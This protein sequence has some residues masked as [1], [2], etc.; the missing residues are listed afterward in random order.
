MSQPTSIPQSAPF[1][2]ILHQ[3]LRW[4][5]RIRW[6]AGLG[7]LATILLADRVTGVS[8]RKPP[9]YLISLFIFAYN[10]GLDHWLSRLGHSPVRSRLLTHANLQIGL[11]FLALILLVAFAGGVQNLFVFYV[12]FHI[13][14][15]S[16]LL[17]RGNMMLVTFFICLACTALF[18]IDYAGLIPS[19]FRLSGFIPS[20]VHKSLAY[21]LGLTYILLTTVS[22]TA[23]LAITISKSLR[24]AERRL[25]GFT[26]EIDKQRLFCQQQTEEIMRLE[27]KKSEFL[28]MASGEL[29]PPLEQTRRIMDRFLSPESGI[30]ASALEQAAEVKANVEFLAKMVG[31]MMETARLSDLAQSMTMEEVDLG[32]VARASANRLLPQFQAKGVELVIEIP[33]DIPSILGDPQGWPR[34]FENLLENAL[35]YSP[36]GSEVEFRLERDWQGERVSAEVKDKGMGIPASE[37]P[38]IFE[39]F[40]RSSRARESGPGT[41]MGLSIAKKVIELHRGTIEVSSREGQGSV[42]RFHVPAGG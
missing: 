6:L 19:G 2:L 25:L 29:R 26:R 3:R 27:E 35:R 28:Q 40:Y 4:M 14:I 18:W 39:D 31:D 33:M 7:I 22:V 37:V 13:V 1:E 15:G 12:I 34:V 8:Y 38:R 32:A 17:P 30:P 24:D 10:I 11:D 41:G 20:Q 16:I 42:F 36:S 5:V 21:V 9:L 23:Y